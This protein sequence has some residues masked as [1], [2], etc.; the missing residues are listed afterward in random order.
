MNA[1]RWLRDL[2]QALRLEVERGCVDLMGRQQRFSAFAAECW[3]A[4]PLSLRTEERSQARSFAEAFATYGQLSVARRQSLVRRCRQWLHDWQRS[5]Q[6]SS[7]VAPPRLRLSPDSCQAPRRGSGRLQL[8]TPLAQ[9]PGVGPKTAARLAALGLL[10]AR[11]LLHYYPRDYLDYAH[12]VRISA[13]EPGRTATIVASVRRCHAFNSP[14]NPNLSILELHLQDCTGRLRVS[15]FFAGKRFAS[16]GWLKG[17]QRLYPPGADVAVSG[18]V[19]DSPY[20]PCFQDPLIE[21]LEDPR[22][23]VRSEQIGRMVPV[24]G[25]TEGLGADRLRQI[26]AGVLGLA[27]AQPDPLPLAIRQHHALMERSGALVAIHRP[28]DAAQLQAARRRLVFDEFLLLQLAL[29][30]RRQEFRSRIAPVLQS[31]AGGATDGTTG[32]ASPTPTPTLVERFL[33]LLPFPLTDAQQRVLS[34]IRRDLARP[35]PMARLVQGDVG[36]G[37]TVVALAALLIAV[38]A[39]C[40]GVLMAPTEVLAEQHVAKIGAWLPQL[41]VSSALLTGSTPAARRRE[42]LQD[43][44]NGQLQVL[45]GTHALLEDPVQF[46]R[47]GLVVVDEQHRFGVRQRNRLLAKGLQP[48]LLTMTATPI[49]RTLALSLHGDLDVSQIDELPPGRQP[50]RTRCLRASQRHEVHALIREQVAAGQRAYVVLPL[51]EESEKI[52]LLSAVAVHRQLQEEV[53]PDLQVGLLHGRLGSDDKQRVLTAFANGDCQVLV[54]TTVVEVGVD[55]PEASVMVIEHAERFG[56][57]QLHQ[58]RGRVGRGSAASQCLLIHDG[59]SALA[60]Q[61]LE[62]LVGSSDGFAI[63]EMD[64]QLRGPGAVLGTR[65]SGLPDLALASLTD[66]GSV[67]ELARDVAQALIAADPNLEHHR[68]LAEALAKQRQRQLEAARLN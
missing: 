36:S 32:T 62:V 3:Q 18:L 54:S 42:L 67:L 13:L 49:P 38:E 7:P 46:Q 51:V 40:Q 35:Q 24:Y 39:G 26:V 64:L 34:E 10:L 2:Q 66:D 44:I 4:V 5:R 6:P 17:Q 8:D 43:L 25:L 37:K 30:R 27:S 60:R 12:L 65:Q 68:G 1:E 11:D 14:R 47:L 29:C 22:A 45:V 21:V 33:D 28:T 57:A 63:A 56:L 61:R 31:P 48:H 15:R 53:F 20:G 52:D 19:K 55:V 58:L 9:M 23:L 59:N 16:P 50:I 41:H